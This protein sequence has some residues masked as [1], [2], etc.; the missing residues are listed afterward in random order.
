MNES[1]DKVMY[2]LGQIDSKLNGINERLDKVNG[3]LGKHDDKIDSLESFRDTANGKATIIGS[4]WG[5]VA[6]IG[7]SVIT[8]FITR[9]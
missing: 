8:W 3:R 7:A 2:M 5:T 4:M 6:G 9:Q 1:H